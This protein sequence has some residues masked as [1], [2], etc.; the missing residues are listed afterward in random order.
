M[1]SSRSRYVSSKVC[2]VQDSTGNWNLAIC[3]SVPTDKKVNYR[4]HTMR[5]T[6]DLC[7]I[8]YAVY[9]DSLLW[10][11]IA[12]ANPEVLYWDQVPMG[13]LIRIPEG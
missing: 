1:I 12:D 11:V 4:W 10:W 2:R 3:R 13:T 8:A 7:K 9:N 6:D 5:Q